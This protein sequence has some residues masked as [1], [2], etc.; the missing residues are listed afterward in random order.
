MQQVVTQSVVWECWNSF[1]ADILSR[2][3]QPVRVTFIY[4]A[5]RGISWRILCQLLSYFLDPE[6]GSAGNWGWIFILSPQSMIY[7]E[8]LVGKSSALRRSSSVCIPHH[9]LCSDHHLVTPLFS[10]SDPLSAIFSS[11]QFCLED[12]LRWKSSWRED[13]GDLTFLM[14]HKRLIRTWKTRRLSTTYMVPSQ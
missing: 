6:E 14:I 11:G 5:S 8:L 10:L 7:R 9:F 2:G 4:S 3:Q 12:L 1:L 13:S